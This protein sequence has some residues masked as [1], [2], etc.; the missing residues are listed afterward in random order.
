MLELKELVLA[1]KFEF[2]LALKL[3]SR[4]LCDPWE[5]DRRPL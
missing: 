4:G 5:N 2:K 3:A 1:F